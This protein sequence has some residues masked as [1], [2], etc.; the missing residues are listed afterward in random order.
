M[1][2]RSEDLLLAV[3]LSLQPASIELL[4]RWDIDWAAEVG[5]AEHL[6]AH[7][8]IGVYA[9]KDG[10]PSILADFFGVG[11]P[12]GIRVFIGECWVAEFTACSYPFLHCFGDPSGGAEVT[13]M[14]FRAP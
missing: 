1:S 6:S 3:L 7:I 10:P 11:T 2:H 8:G 4:R 9:A 12:Y 13:G 5:F 14:R